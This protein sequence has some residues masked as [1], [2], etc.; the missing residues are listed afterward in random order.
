MTVQGYR[1]GFGVVISRSLFGKERTMKKAIVAFM[2][3]AGMALMMVGCNDNT[4]APKG[5]GAPATT[6]APKAV[7]PTSGEK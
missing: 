7:P 3:V 2:V 6:P 4:P 5:P 1:T